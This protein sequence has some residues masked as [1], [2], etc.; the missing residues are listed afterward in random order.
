MSFNIQTSASS[1]NIGSHSSGAVSSS[2]SAFMITGHS[3][4]A[5]S[6][7]RTLSYSP[8]ENRGGFASSLV[9]GASSSQFEA[10]GVGSPSSASNIPFSKSS[11]DTTKLILSFL[12][13]LE[14]IPSC[15][16]VCREW[17]RIL[18]DP[19]TFRCLSDRRVPWGFQRMSAAHQ[20]LYAIGEAN[21]T[22]DMESL[23]GRM[24]HI[25]LR[26]NTETD[27]R[28]IRT[29]QKA[30]PFIIYGGLILSA[31]NT[32]HSCTNFEFLP[33][34]EIAFDFQGK[35]YNAMNITDRDNNFSASF[36]MELI[37]LVCSILLLIDL[38]RLP[39]AAAW[40][41]EVK[42]HLLIACFSVAN[43]ILTKVIFSRSGFMIPFY[44]EVLAF[45]LTHL[46]HSGMLSR[47]VEIG[48]RIVDKTLKIGTGVCKA[49]LEAIRAAARACRRAVKSKVVELLDFPIPS[50]PR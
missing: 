16:S 30:I 8:W 25:L 29:L 45:A 12:L 32:N 27:Q 49:G 35:S 6:T 46:A 26:S 33:G 50:F 39:A 14:N 28:L 3:G 18:E 1:G 40:P 10:A 38:T 20:Y 37:V 11:D 7:E 13:D 48:T 36:R 5:V 41:P 43:A 31:P 17:R 24:T 22:D 2:S 21:L 15:A 34:K 23:K 9:A 47:P 4:S 44:G 19:R 42:R